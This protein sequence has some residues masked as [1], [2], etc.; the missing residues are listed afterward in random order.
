M[1]LIGQYTLPRLLGENSL[2][3]K[4]LFSM[5]LF[6]KCIG[7][8]VVTRVFAL[9][10]AVGCAQ[11]YALAAAA[12]VDDLNNKTDQELTELTARWGDLSPA[13]RRI[14]LAEVRTRMQLRRQQTIRQHSGRQQ[15]RIV[16][17]VR[18]T[19]RYGRIVRKE[20]GTVVVQTQ[21]IDPQGRQT[22]SEQPAPAQPT[23][24]RRNGRVTFGFGFERRVRRQNP[25]QPNQP[26]SSQ[27]VATTGEESVETEPRSQ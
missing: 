4:C 1:T 8:K 26:E 20:D 23:T 2:F 6:S 25:V 18:V 15:T 21:T 17:K 11:S 24:G 5:R 14:L 3:K 7:K 16:P 9:C 22:V 13:E 12:P 27:N 19:R 10:M